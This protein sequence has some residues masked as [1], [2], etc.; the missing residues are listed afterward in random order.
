LLYLTSF[1]DVVP[2]NRIEAMKK[3]WGYL[4]KQGSSIVEQSC[5]D[6]L[7]LLIRQVESA[8]FALLLVAIGSF[9]QF[10]K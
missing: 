8:S 6:L 1:I 5:D 7:R 9:D 3:I 10:Y 2:S 4:H